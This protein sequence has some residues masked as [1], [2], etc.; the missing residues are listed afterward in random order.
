MMKS[1]TTKVVCPRRLPTQPQLRLRPTCL[2]STLKSIALST[3][4]Q[5]ITRAIAE[6][7]L[8]TSSR[9]LANCSSARTWSLLQPQPHMACLLPPLRPLPQFN[10][11][12]VPMSP[13]ILT[14]SLLLLPKNVSQ[15]NSPHCPLTNPTHYLYH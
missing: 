3:G 12:N 5:N 9:L 7:L 1:T 15:M 14:R 11:T 13:W 4:S 8:S 10:Q 6:L 2:S